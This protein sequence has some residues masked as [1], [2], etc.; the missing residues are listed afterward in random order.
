[1]SAYIYSLLIRFQGAAPDPY[2]EDGKY[3]FA[4]HILSLGAPKIGMLNY[5][6]IRDEHGVV[7][8]ADI[9]IPNAAWKRFGSSNRRGIDFGGQCIARLEYH[10]Q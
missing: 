5:C 3:L 6:G 1:M 8:V 4:D 7:M 2:D 10:D 9:G